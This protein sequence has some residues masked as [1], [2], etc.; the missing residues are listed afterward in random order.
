VVCSSAEVFGDRVEGFRA[1]EEEWWDCGGMMKL[2]WSSIEQ[3]HSTAAAALHSMDHDRNGV[4]DAS[5]HIELDSRYASAGC[6][7]LAL[8]ILEYKRE[9]TTSS[10]TGSKRRTDMYGPKSWLA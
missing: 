3:T 2:Q 10:T 8:K 7:V 1:G 5:D 9:N 6:S 4:A